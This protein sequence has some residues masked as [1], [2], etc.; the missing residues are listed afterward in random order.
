[1]AINPAQN[2]FDALRNI[3]NANTGFTGI[4]REQSGSVGLNTFKNI[5]G[6]ISGRYKSNVEQEEQERE[7]F[8]KL[9][10]KAAGLPET[11]ENLEKYAFRVDPFGQAGIRA[12]TVKAATTY[13][14][15]L[16]RFKN[17]FKQG[18][19][20][21]KVPGEGAL[22]FTEELDDAAKL[23]IEKFTT[24]VKEAK[25]V[26]TTTELARTAER[27][28]RVPRAMATLHRIGGRKGFELSTK[29]LGG[30]L[31]KAKYEG[32]EGLF[33]ENEIDDLFNIIKDR[34]DL[35]YFTQLNTSKGLNKML[36]GEIPTTQELK[37]LQNTFGKNL[38]DALRSK[39]EFWAKL[40]DAGVEIVN[41]PRALISSMD[42][43]APFR[44]GVLFV[45]RKPK[46]FFKAFVT[47]PKQF[48]SQ[49]I[50]DETMYTI[51][52]GQRFKGMQQ[53]GL[54]FTDITGQAIGYG[55]KEERFMSNFAT[56]FPIVGR[57]VKASERAYVGF[58]NKLRADVWDDIARQYEKNGITIQ[59]DPEVYEGLARFINTFT[60]RGKLPASIEGAAPALNGVLFSPRLMASRL[61]ALNPAFYAKL[62]DPVRKEAA[63]AMLSFVATGL[64]VVS[65]ASLHPDADVSTDPTS[66]DFGKIRIGNARWDIWGG[67]QQYV[68][69]ASQILLQETTSATSGK[70]Y[71]VGGFGFKGMQKS[72]YGGKNQLELAWQFIQG[73][74]APTTALVAD[75]M[76]GQTLVGED[77]EFGGEMWNKFIPLYIQDMYDAYED[78]GWGGVSGVGAPAF[79]GVGTQTFKARGKTGALGLPILPELPSL[80][81]LPKL[82]KGA[83]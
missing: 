37:L 55:A 76:R 69:V 33:K 9:S 26:R 62:P 8:T 60:G 39:R 34:K 11:E 20:G 80:P 18:F 30:T 12:S 77:V 52:R 66:S 49:R 74:F 59:S 81:E 70:K 54:E 51:Q 47:M 65:L 6:A 61:S 42:M 73:K 63:K 83:F 15:K 38:V 44:Q 28:K 35:D 75:L 58:L 24:A 29:K 50:F 7:K 40:K 23:V 56:R 3:K 67:F 5:W 72:S 53:A 71:D 68:R 41:I 16:G 82:P 27:G 45:A 1:M 36:V 79:F 14:S 46:Q 2:A 10:L 19:S 43:S 48:G 25:P 21:R 4:T 78:M 17:W 13:V 31:P 22:R 32:I 57:L 64:G